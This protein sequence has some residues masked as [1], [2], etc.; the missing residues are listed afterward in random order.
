VPRVGKGASASA[1]KNAGSLLQ[2][3]P[4]HEGSGR[5]RGFNPSGH[6]PYRRWSLCVLIPAVEGRYISTPIGRCGP[7]TCAA[8]DRIGVAQA[9]NGSSLGRGPREGGMQRAEAVISIAGVSNGQ[10]RITATSSTPRGEVKLGTLARHCV[11]ASAPRTA[12][13]VTECRPGGFTADDTDPPGAGRLQSS[14]PAPRL[15][16]L[17]SP[18]PGV[19]SASP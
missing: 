7:R 13:A 17:M 16:A 12:D 11:T 6:G 9:P 1:S 5:R 18:V 19:P 4:I 15:G 8:K 2:A 10:A 14:R 3:Q